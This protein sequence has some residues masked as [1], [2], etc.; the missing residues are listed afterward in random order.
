M[1]VKLFIDLIIIMQQPRLN[2]LEIKPNIWGKT[3][4]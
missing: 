3:F 2:L 4:T 1:S